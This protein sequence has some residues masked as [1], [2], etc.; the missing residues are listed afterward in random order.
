[1]TRYFSFIGVTTAQSSILPIFPRWRDVLDLG[2]DVE[3]EGIDLPVHANPE[4]YRDVLMGIKND[5]AHAG[6]VVTTHKIDLLHAARDLFDW[7]D[8]YAS[9]CDEVSCIAKREGRLMGWAKDPISAGKVLDRMLGPGYFGTTGGHVLCFGAGGSGV[10]ITL[11]LLTRSQ[12]AD[13]PAAITVTNRSRGRLV[14]MQA[15]HERL[16]SDVRVGYIETED[17]AIQDSLVE[18]LQAH[19]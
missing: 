1:M 9:L 12:R 18:K 17:S 8:E 10:A 16:G 3:V 2:R 4:R 13:R 19:W 14:A 15:L 11:H 7:L 6:A 5:P